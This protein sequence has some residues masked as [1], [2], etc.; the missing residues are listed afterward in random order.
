MP[1]YVVKFKDRQP[2]RVYASTNYDAKSQ[3]ATQKRQR[4]ETKTD[5]MKKI[6]SCILSKKQ[7]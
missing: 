6:T 3:A 4:G 7:Y 1:Y 2:V 5:A